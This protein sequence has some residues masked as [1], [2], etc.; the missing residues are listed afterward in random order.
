MLKGLKRPVEIFF[1][2]FTLLLFANLSFAQTKEIDSLR[3]FLKSEKK[4]TLMV[5][6]MKILGYD[7]YARENYDSA[8][9]YEEQALSLCNVLGYKK[10][11][12]G[13]YETIGLIAN[14]KGKYSEALQNFLQSYRIATD[15]NY[16]KGIAHATND[17]GMVYFNT[18]DYPTALKYYLQ[19]LKIKEKLGDKSSIVFTYNNLV[20]LYKEEHN[21]E[22]AKNY[23][24]KIVRINGE[25]RDSMGM[26]YA[27]SS[28]AEIYLL[29]HRYDSAMYY[30]NA[31]KA[32]GEKLNNK[33]FLAYS[34][35]YIGEVLMDEGVY[36]DAFSSFKD[37]LQIADSIRDKQLVSKIYYNLGEVS[38]KLN[39]FPDACNFYEQSLF[40][41]KKIDDKKRIMQAYLALTHYDSVS[42]NLNAVL[43]HYENYIEYRDSMFNVASARKIENE[44]ITYENE[45]QQEIVKAESER[46]I[47]RQKILRDVFIG[48]FGLALIFSFIFFRQRVK[49]GKEKKRSEDLLLNILPAETAEELKENGRTVAKDY[50][51]VTVLF[52]DFKNF[53]KVSETL[54]AQEL[55]NEINYCYSK[56]DEIV[57][58]FGIEKIK[59]IGDGYMAAGGLPVKN[60]TNAYDA[61]KAALAIRDFIEE[62]K[63]RRE[64]EGKPFFEIRIGI[65]TGHVVAGVVGI[66]KFAYD[67][68][69]DTVNIASRMESSGEPGKVNISGTTYE[70]VKDQFTCTYRG[71]VMA[72][73][74]GEIDMYYVEGLGAN[75]I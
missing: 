56:F 26:G 40:I 8:L 51:M 3:A 62:E 22:E 13:A 5:M 23:L 16:S 68:W 10:G 41:A 53:T 12:T 18:G 70:F 28:L 47:L 55:V 25:T 31:S 44:K 19:S 61:V 43:E 65:N 73:N 39:R 2:F 52:T 35:S 21:F 49:I 45:A 24:V 7:F 59:T 69:G 14:D 57:T 72:K 17:L 36:E 63:Q 27:Y 46:R 48:G 4:D 37:A 64:S 11:M 50:D 30:A 29:S 66:K 38:I 20:D 75:R 1:L 67:I 33:I 34:G 74:K 60:T 58:R 32:I 54:N 42:G 15:M 9:K 71:K 6:N